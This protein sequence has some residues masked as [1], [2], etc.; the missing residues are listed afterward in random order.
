MNPKT[1]LETATARPWHL[2]DN[3]DR[4][5]YFGIGNGVCHICR[6]MITGCVNADEADANAA[7]IVQSVNEYVALCA[8]AEAA[9]A[10]LSD[11]ERVHGAIDDTHEMR[12]S[13][14]TLATIRK[15][16]A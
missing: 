15:G 6:A 12:Y 14:S 1:L 10:L 13:L 8:V 2:G 3:K 7:L 5:G 11:W 16:E 4:T 9:K